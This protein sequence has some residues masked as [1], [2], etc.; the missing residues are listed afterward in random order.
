[1]HEASLFPPWSNTVFAI[2]V[3]ALAT[4]PVAAIAGLM[5]YVRTPYF[6]STGFPVT[7]PVQ[8][9][10]RHHVADDGIDCRY[11][12]SSVEKSP[13][14]GIPATSVCMN[15]HSQIWNQSPLLE[16]VRASFFTD[17][18]LA[19]IR[20]HRVPDFVFFNHSIHV[21]KGVGC[22][23]CHGRVDQMALA[24]QQQPLSMEWCLDC[25]RAPERNLRPRE[26]VTHMEWKPEGDPLEIGR[27]LKNA[28]NVQS[29][30]DCYTCHR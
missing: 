9:D 17:Q 20:V 24:T 22:V 8:F 26:E 13:N 5:I 4:A 19:F 1:M 23:T 15:C 2:G 3:G 14:A 7:Q 6:T 16:P 29:L 18:P 11:C 10:H 30:T 28:Y 21:N 12:H 27:R 25:H